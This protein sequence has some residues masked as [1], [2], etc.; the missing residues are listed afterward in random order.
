[1]ADRRPSR[2]RQ[3]STRRCGRYCFPTRPSRLTRTPSTSRTR[4]SATRRK[5][6][7]SN[8]SA[9]S[10]RDR[11]PDL[12]IANTAPA[13]KF[14]LQLPRRAVSG[15]AGGLCR[16]DAACRIAPAGKIA[17]CHRHR[18]AS[19]RRSKRWTWRCKI[20]PATRRLHV[21]AYAPAVDGFQERVRID[22]G[23]L[24]GA[25]DR[26]LRRRTDAARDARGARGACPRTA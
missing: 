19:P 11:R 18:C 15:R 7:Y 16:R 3:P 21:V 5:R 6:R 26:D 1:M 20:H 14:V 12:V 8:T 10:S 24:L 25:C 4:N 13:L 17:R 2:Q 22:A 9:S 23:G